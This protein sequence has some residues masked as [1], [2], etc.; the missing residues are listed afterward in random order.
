[1]VGNL[2]IRSLRNGYASCRVSRFRFE[3]LQ[4]N[5]HNSVL[6]LISVLSARKAACMS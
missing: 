2:R 3:F 6:P 1:M 5:G 4:E